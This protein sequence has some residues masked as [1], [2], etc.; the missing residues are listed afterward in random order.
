MKLSCCLNLYVMFVCLFL[1]FLY[2]LFYVFELTVR[3]LGHFT[4][5]VGVRP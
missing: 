5:N 3:V 4:S 1:V 2:V